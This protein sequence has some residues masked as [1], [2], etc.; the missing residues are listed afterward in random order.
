MLWRRKNE[1]NGRIPL[2]Q[3][4]HFAR[5]KEK[6]PVQLHQWV[7]RMKVGFTEDM[8]AV[9]LHVQHF[10]AGVFITNSPPY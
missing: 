4:Y 1:C 10:V 2:V 6:L 5:M 7:F 9:I 3:I 8:V